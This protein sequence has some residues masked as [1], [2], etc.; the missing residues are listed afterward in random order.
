M[1]G[2]GLAKEADLFFMAVLERGTGWYQ[3][4]DTQGRGGHEVSALH[5]SAASFPLSS[6]VVSSPAGGG[7]ADGHRDP[8][9]RQED[10][11]TYHLHIHSL[12]LKHHKTKPQ[13]FNGYVRRIY[14]Y[15]YI[16][17]IFVIFVIFN[18]NLPPFSKSLPVK[19][20]I[21]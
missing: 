21:T 6:P 4:H 8:L 11:G 15:I 2:A 13:G 12:L 17:V 19:Q 14:I 16:Y 1:T 18:P 10:G 20:I 5:P 3:E 7:G 9:D